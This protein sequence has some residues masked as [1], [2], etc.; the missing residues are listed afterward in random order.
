[1]VVIPAEAGIHVYYPYMKKILI[2]ITKGEMGGAQVFVATLARA[3]KKMGYS[4]TVG[5]GDGNYLKDVLTQDSIPW[6][7]FKWLNGTK[8]PLKNILFLLEMRRCIDQGAFDVVHFNGS[9]TLFG[10][11]GAKW[12]R[13][14]PMTLFTVHGLSVLDPHFKASSSM[15]R[16]YFL[17]FKL[18]L[19]YVDKTI[20]VSKT[21]QAYAKR[22][23][24]TDQETTVIHNGIDLEQLDFLLRGKARKTLESM[25]KTD[26]ADKYLIGS[27]GRLAYQK[28][29]EFLI[30]HFQKIL[31]NIPNAVA[32]II[33]EGPERKAYEAMIEQ[34][35][36]SNAVFLVGELTDARRYQKAFDL[37]ILP[38]RYEGMSLALIEALCAR[39]PILASNV[40]GAPEIVKNIGN[41][42]TLDD[43]D[44]FMK[45]LIA[46]HA[47]RN[48]KTTQDDADD[49]GD[50]DSTIMAHRYL[51]M[52]EGGLHDSSEY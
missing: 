42:Y 2:V 10:A 30:K 34:H 37:F 45:K 51:L 35:G 18:L 26:L 20:F 48:A 3:L 15:K 14:K 46:L 17:V 7:R 52:M 24:L 4:I 22:I 23:G 44:D 16:V 6:I 33:G 8:N 36:L 29:Y 47:A 43:A 38:S 50:F 19:A 41:K 49:C 28:N 25:A 13:R 32:I 12:T 1:M 31:L 21:N 5:F 27:M 39:V 40:G 11:I 9:N